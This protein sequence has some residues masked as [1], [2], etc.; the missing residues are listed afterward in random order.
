MISFRHW[1]DINPASWRPAA[2]TCSGVE[3]AGIVDGGRRAQAI[4]PTA[5][6][7]RPAI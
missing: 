1:L 7:I 4:N 5:S 3:T 6:G 2:S